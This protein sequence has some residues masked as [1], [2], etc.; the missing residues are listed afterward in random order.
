M[1]GMSINQHRLGHYREELSFTHVRSKG[2][3]DGAECLLS[4]KCCLF[5]RADRATGSVFTARIVQNT[6]ELAHKC[7]KVINRVPSTGTRGLYC[8]LP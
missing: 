2:S 3:R 1:F 7:V 8:L 4:T 5:Y 6:A